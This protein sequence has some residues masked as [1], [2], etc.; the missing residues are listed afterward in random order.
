MADDVASIADQTSYADIHPIYTAADTANMQAG[1]DE[2]FLDNAGN[3]T[4]GA[5]LSGLA[6]IYNTGANLLGAEQF[7]VAKWMNENDQHMGA[8]Y[9]KNKQLV[10]VAGFAVTSFIPGGLALKGV[11]LAKAGTMLGPFGRALGYAS[12]QQKLY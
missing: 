11:Q 8:Y 5:V 3:F 9:A 2:S 10:D 6:S 1:S 12:S 7:D 4:Y